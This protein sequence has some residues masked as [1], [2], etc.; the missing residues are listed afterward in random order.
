M[1]GRLLAVDG[2]LKC[3]L[4]LFDGQG[5]LI[6]HKS[7]RVPDRSRMRVA[8]ADILKRWGPVTQVVFEGGGDVA[9]VWRAVC[10]RLGV[11]FQ[12]VS[13]EDWRRDLLFRRQQRTGSQA[14]QVALKLAREVIEDSG[15]PRPKGLRHDAAEAILTGTWWF[16]QLGTCR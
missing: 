16:R 3:G 14:K 13:A 2:G 9:Q 15:L 8:A 6:R 10:N 12:T 1:M 5:S 4:A 11:R 7:R